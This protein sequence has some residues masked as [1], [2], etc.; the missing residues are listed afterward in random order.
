MFPTGKLLGKVP[1]SARLEVFMYCGGMALTWAYTVATLPSLNDKFDLR[2][3]DKLLQ[4]ICAPHE[5]EHTRA[6]THAHVLSVPAERKN[7][8]LTVF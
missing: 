5:M 3:D 7:P 1:S 4:L 6:P 2:H 8:C